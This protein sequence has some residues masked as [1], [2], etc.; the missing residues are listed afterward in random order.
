MAV[1]P[2]ALNLDV[3]ATTACKP[4]AAEA[5]TVQ[6]LEAKATFAIIDDAVSAV[7]ERETRAEH[8]A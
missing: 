2:V 7:V 3:A 1:A 5:P 6:E 4:E 8:A